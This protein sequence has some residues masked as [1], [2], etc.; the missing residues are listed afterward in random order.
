VIVCHCKGVSDRAI[1]KAV[2][3]GACTHRDVARACQAG[4]RC[5]GCVNAVSE[6]LESERNESAAAALPSLAISAG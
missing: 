6:I 4:S 5:G 2:R 1:R 3:A